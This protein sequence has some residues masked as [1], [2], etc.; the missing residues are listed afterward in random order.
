MSLIYPDRLTTLLGNYRVGT[1]DCLIDRGLVVLAQSQDYRRQVQARMKPI[2]A[3]GIKK[4]PVAQYHVSRKIDG[5]FNC[6]VCQD[7]EAILVNPGGTVRVGLDFLDEIANEFTVDGIRRAVIA[8]ELWFAR[9]NG[10]ERVHDV[11]RVARRPESEGE[12]ARLAF[13]A[14]DI[15]EWDGQTFGSF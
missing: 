4:L 1:A 9:P 13:S 2:D 3:D 11:T 5:E 14:F 8:G 6:L 7:G 10:R 15:I 12:L